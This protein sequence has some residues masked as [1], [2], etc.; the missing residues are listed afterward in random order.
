MPTNI[1][2]ATVAISTSGYEVSKVPAS[3]IRPSCTLT[4]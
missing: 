3:L 2:P 1:R 4:A